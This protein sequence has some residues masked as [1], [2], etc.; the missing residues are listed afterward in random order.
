G[1]G[2]F[3][4]NSLQQ[5]RLAAID[6]AVAS[7]SISLNTSVLYLGQALGAGLGGVLVADGIGPSI[8]IAAGA[9]LAVAAG[10]S[11]AASRVPAPR[12][13]AAG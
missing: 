10:L 9:L 2:T 3:S 5:S 13:P 6:L 4:M 7:A 1:L 11:I 12:R 8:T